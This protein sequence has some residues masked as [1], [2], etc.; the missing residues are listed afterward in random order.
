MR[1]LYV[2]L[3]LVIVTGM[4]GLCPAQDL[5]VH[6]GTYVQGV[7]AQVVQAPCGPACSAPASRCGSHQYYAAWQRPTLMAHVGSFNCGCCGSYK[8]PVPPQ[9]TYH[10]PGMYS[11]PCVTAYAS[12]WRFPSLM[13]Y[14]SQLG[15]ARDVSARMVRLNPPPPLEAP[16]N[17][18]PTDHTVKR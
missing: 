4:T 5:V 10:W 6:E 3:S 2:L 17:S 14:Q 12:P 15:R 1:K 11:Q 7:P 9:Y 8:F 13:M 18:Q 16:D